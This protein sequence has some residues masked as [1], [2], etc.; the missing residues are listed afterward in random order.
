MG[1]LERLK[2]RHRRPPFVQ[3]RPP[4]HPTQ[5]PDVLLFDLCGP[6]DFIRVLGAVV[7]AQSQGVA[8][9]SV[10]VLDAQ[11]AV[12]FDGVDLAI[13][14]LGQAT[15][16]R[17]GRTVF[18]FLSH[19]VTA[20]EDTDGVGVVDFQ[21][22]KVAAGQA[23]GLLRVFYDVGLVGA[24]GDDSFFVQRQFDVDRLDDR[25]DTADGLG[26]EGVA[27]FV[28]QAQVLGVFRAFAGFQ[29]VAADGEFS[30]DFFHAMGG[31]TAGVPVMY[32]LRSR[33]QE[34]G[35]SGGRDVR[36]F[37]ERFEAWAASVLFH[38]RESTAGW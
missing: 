1:V 36:C 14:Y 22:V 17:Q 6:E 30:G 25:V 27:G 11:H 26:I 38:E 19:T 18:N 37:E 28:E 32:I 9:Q 16:N 4:E 35:K 10:Q 12:M 31:H 34:F 8:R 21:G 33:I 23:D 24:R 5:H 20:H 15:V 7:A 3:G 13:D 29:P 2:K